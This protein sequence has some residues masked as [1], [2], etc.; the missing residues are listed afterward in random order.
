MK[1]YKPYRYK[2]RVVGTHKPYVDVGFD[3]FKRE[4]SNNLAKIA[5]AQK[6]R[7]QPTKKQ[8]R[9]LPPRLRQLDTQALIAEL[10][11]LTKKQRNKRLQVLRAN[12]EISKNQARKIKRALRP[13]Y[14]PNRK[15]DVTTVPKKYVD[16]IKSRHW[17]NRRN[18]YWQ[19]H[20][21]AC[22]AC[23]TTQR[24]DLHHMVYEKYG[25]EP[26]ANLIGLCRTH[27]EGYHTAN[28][29]QRNMIRKTTA[30]VIQV[31]KELHR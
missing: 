6:P 5:N 8:K 15:R 12:N 22:A 26:D 4:A 30:Y 10:S 2:L 23:G 13:F 16:Y 11:L 28:G 1:L 17:Y 21:R 25:E 31:Q 9:V 7:E 20:T 3:V 14:A 19:T 24:I 29:V 27:H 18:R